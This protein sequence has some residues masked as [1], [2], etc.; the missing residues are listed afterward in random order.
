MS[1]RGYVA[2]GMNGKVVHL[3]RLIAGVD[4]VELDHIN[5]DKLDNRRSNLRPATRSQNNANKGP[6]NGKTYKGTFLNIKN[7]PKFV[8]KGKIDTKQVYIGSFDTEIEAAR[9]YD[10]WAIIHHGEFAYLNFEVAA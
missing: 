6:T 3:H 10:A 5:R 4:G 9:A 1:H 2:T 7:S 8:A